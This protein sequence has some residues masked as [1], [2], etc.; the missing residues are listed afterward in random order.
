MT[1]GCSSRGSV[2]RHFAGSLGAPAEREL[3]MH[4]PGCDA[5]RERYER[6]LLLARLDRSVASAEE[7]LARGLG[8]SPRRP[9]ARWLAFAGG[10]AA[11]CAALVLVLHTPEPAYLA[12]GA[13]IADPDEA[14]DVYRIDGAPRLVLDGVIHPGDELAFAYRNRRGWTHAMVFAIDQT[15]RVYWYHPGWTDADASPT[16]VPIESGASRHELPDAVSHRLPPGRIWLH[17][18]FSDD[19]PDVRAVEHGLRPD[20]HE[21]LIIALDVV[22]EVGGP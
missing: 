2:D 15:G 7:R 9:R 14:L 11:A 8:L 10:L 12:R 16:A 20:R 13:P 4:L 3:R 18:L 17:A 21:E 19:A 22:Q 1:M 5:C 6:Y